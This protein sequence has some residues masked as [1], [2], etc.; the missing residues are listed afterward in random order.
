MSRRKTDRPIDD[1]PRTE[2]GFRIFAKDEGDRRH[3]RVVESSLAARGAH[4]WIFSD[5]APGYLDSGIHLSVED[6]ALV[7]AGLT[8]FIAEAEAGGLTER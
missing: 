8:R 2:R 1:S 7:L 3:V 4:V 5:P 6:A